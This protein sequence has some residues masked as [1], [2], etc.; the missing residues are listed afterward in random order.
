MMRDDDVDPVIDLLAGLSAPAP[1]S[2]RDD[3]IRARCHALLLRRR[4]PRARAGDIALA[5]V[6]C[7]YALVAMLEIFRLTALL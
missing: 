5:F 1:T 7:A 2:S 3:R 4:R 6:V